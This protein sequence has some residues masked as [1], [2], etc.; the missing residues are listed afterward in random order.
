MRAVLRW[1]LALAPL[2]QRFPSERYS[3]KN[4]W[5][6]E[7]L[8]VCLVARKYFWA[9]S[10]GWIATSS[11]LAESRLLMSLT[12]EQRRVCTSSFLSR[13]LRCGKWDSRFVRLASRNMNSLLRKVRHLELRDQYI[14]ELVSSKR[15]SFICQVHGTFLQQRCVF[16]RGWVFR[17][18]S[19]ESPDSWLSPA[20]KLAGKSDFV[21]LDLLL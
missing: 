20:R 7:T 15:L 11:L 6:E 4:E 17:P 3:F 10:I 2:V 1:V 5:S 14:Q 9:L 18:R 19:A 16:K 12:K 21:V 8:F 13:I